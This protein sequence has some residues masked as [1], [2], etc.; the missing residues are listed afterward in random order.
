MP[1]GHNKVLGEMSKQP[2]ARAH[3]VAIGEWPTMVKEARTASFDTLVGHLAS[4]GYEGVEFNPGGFNKYFPG[5]SSAVAGRKARR[6]LEKAGLAY[7]GGT[8]YIGDEAWRKL[9]WIDRIVEQL[10]L[11]TDLGGGFASYQINLHP[12]Y[13]NTGGAYRSD[14]RYLAEIARNITDLRQ[15]NWDHGLNFYIEAHIDRITEDPA[16][17]CRILDMA[18]CEIT[19]DLSHYLFRGMT[20]GAHVERILDHM[21]H[22]HVRMARKYGDLSAVVTDP[23]ADWEQK[24]VTWQLFQ[25][26]KRGLAGG[27]SSRTIVGETGPMHLV[28]DTLTQD[29]ALVPLYRAMARYAD[30]SAQGITMKVEDPGDLRPWG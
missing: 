23:K 9:G 20:K 10:K 19:G 6:A 28:T 13:L 14:E 2:Q 26:M 3:R 25:F 27:L 5:D 24:G 22:T 29:A 18:A 17:T 1:I 4:A 16:A 30:A 8:L 12:D 11:V 21:G 15:A 7:F